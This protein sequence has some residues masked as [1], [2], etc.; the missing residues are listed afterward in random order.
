MKREKR[1]FHLSFFENFFQTSEF[2]KIK[3]EEKDE[4]VVRND[5]SLNS[6]QI[7]MNGQPILPTNGKGTKRPNGEVNHLQRQDVVYQ[8]NEFFLDSNKRPKYIGI[9]PTIP[10]SSFTPHL[11]PSS[12]QLK[13]P[14]N[15]NA[16]MPN[17][18]AP[19]LLHQQ[20]NNIIRSASLQGPLTQPHIPP[21]GYFIQPA[22]FLP[23]YQLMPHN[24]SLSHPSHPL[25]Q[26]IKLSNDVDAKQKVPQIREP[27]KGMSLDQLDKQASQ[28]LVT[29]E[30][31]D[32]KGIDVKEERVNNL[33]HLLESKDQLIPPHLPPSLPSNSDALVKK[34][35]INSGSS[36]QKPSK[37]N[38]SISTTISQNQGD[39]SLEL[40]YLRKEKTRMKRLLSTLSSSTVAFNSQVSPPA[41]LG[42]FCLESENSV[43]KEGTVRVSLIFSS[44]FFY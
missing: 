40:G 36:E 28:L 44:C 16:L 27:M 24:Y 13:K 18:G 25:P 20:N 29:Y 15:A 33:S 2:Q 38:G 21:S 10:S 37:I 4:K 30:S 12:H 32:K 1:F 9:I 19:P 34:E 5:S 17:N 43:L 22:V 31:Q 3:M 8:R 26:P 7:M 6:Q 39:S 42:L 41:Q 23:H 14:L 35:G 11:L